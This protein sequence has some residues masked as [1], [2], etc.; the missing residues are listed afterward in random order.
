[1]RI[2]KYIP[3]IVIM[4]LPFLIERLPERGLFFYY[5]CGA[6]CCFLSYNDVFS[7]LQTVTFLFVFVFVFIRPGREVHLNCRIILSISLGCNAIKPQWARNSSTKIL[8]RASWITKIKLSDSKMF[9]INARIEVVNGSHRRDSYYVSVYRPC[10]RIQD[11]YAISCL[12]YFLI[13]TNLC[14]SLTLILRV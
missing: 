5:Y 10:R 9:F 2:Q 13:W 14:N 3:I 7:F 6:S 8:P 4:Y 11:I 12:K 1:M